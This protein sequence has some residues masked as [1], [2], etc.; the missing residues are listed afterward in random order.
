MSKNNT[1]E[2][3]NMLMSEKSLDLNSLAYDSENKT[4]KLN[5]LKSKLVCILDSYCIKA[6]YR[7]K[8]HK[9]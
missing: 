8:L 3:L 2:I 7:K 1:T 5:C 6:V 4:Q 9:N